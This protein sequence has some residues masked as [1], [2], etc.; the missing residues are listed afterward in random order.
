[1]IAA[2]VAVVAVLCCVALP[3]VI[4]AAGTLTA[5]AV[6]GLTAGAVV[7]LAACLLAAKRLGSSKGC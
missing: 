2:L 1:L 5:G 4:A 6:L 7:L 3:V